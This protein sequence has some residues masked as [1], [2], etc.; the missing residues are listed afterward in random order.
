M[1]KRKPSYILSF[2]FVFFLV[3]II[4][5]VVFYYLLSQKRVIKKPFSSITSSQSQSPKTS[6]RGRILAEEYF[7]WRPTEVMGY[8]NQKGEKVLV[9]LGKLEEK[10]KDFWLIR[11][12]QGEVLKIL[13]TP[14]TQFFLRQPIVEKDRFKGERSLPY[15]KEGF[16]EGEI[17]MVEWLSPIIKNEKDL[18]DENG[19]IKPE[20]R[21]ISSWAIS[22]RE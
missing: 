11:P 22:K 20:Y 15:F 19:Q 2:L 16:K 7:P 17:I 12:K 14:Q 4:S 9:I 18:I 10:N 21:Q 8:T 3:V 6:E 1:T 13:L 5:E